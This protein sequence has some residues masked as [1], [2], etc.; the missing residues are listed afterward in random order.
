MQRAD[1]YGL[2]GVSPPRRPVTGPPVME[3][4]AAY[5]QQQDR[6]AEAKDQDRRRRV[7]ERVIPLGSFERR[8]GGPAVLSSAGTVESRASAALAADD[9][10]VQWAVR[11]LL[12]KDFEPVAAAFAQDRDF[13]LRVLRYIEDLQARLKAE[14]C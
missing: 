1:D 10:R 4:V 5:Y 8:D 11:A 7:V 3:Q 12:R 2:L 9:S 13:G 14:Q 6:R